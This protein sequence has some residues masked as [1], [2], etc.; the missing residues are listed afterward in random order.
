MQL[1]VQEREIKC[2]LFS[3]SAYELPSKWINTS[4]AWSKLNSGAIHYPKGIA[5]SLL[6][7]LSQAVIPLIYYG[8]VIGWG[9]AVTPSCRIMNHGRQNISS[10]PVTP[11]E[12]ITR[13]RKRFWWS[14]VAL[15]S[16]LWRRHDSFSD[17][18]RSVPIWLLS[19]SWLK[20]QR[21]PY[22]TVTVD[23]KPPTATSRC[24]S[25]WK[26]NEDPLSLQLI[27]WGPSCCVHLGFALDFGC[28]KESGIRA[29]VP[30]SAQG[31]GVAG[32]A[33]LQMWWKWYLGQLEGGSA[34]CVK[35]AGD[36]SDSSSKSPMNK[37]KEM[38]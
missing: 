34:T 25:G 19:F 38:Y 15:K 13:G 27:M 11:K 28:Y 30:D 35:T 12:V 4:A 8:M 17:Y 21:H 9:V 29:N 1:K 7:L 32:F 22:R 31:F 16:L 18:L 37:V 36:D 10:Y 23:L 33:V 2:F 26:P 14:T 24:S 6:T 3:P 20:G 5:T